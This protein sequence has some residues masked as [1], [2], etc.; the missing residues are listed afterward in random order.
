MKVENRKNWC[1][2]LK[3]NHVSSSSPPSPLG[4]TCPRMLTSYY[5]YLSS[6][7]GPLLGLPAL[8]G[9]GWWQLVPRSVGAT[10]PWSSLG[11]PPCHCGWSKTRW[12]AWAAVGNFHYIVLWAN[13]VFNILNPLNQIDYSIIRLFIFLSWYDNHDIRSVIRKFTTSWF[14]NFKSYWCSLGFGQF[15]GSRFLLGFVTTVLNFAFGEN[16]KSHLIKRNH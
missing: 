4:L 3:K 9:T 16:G 12:F 1:Q 5:L 11:C 6:S 8:G 2:C 7:A 10:L 14:H 15:H 13:P